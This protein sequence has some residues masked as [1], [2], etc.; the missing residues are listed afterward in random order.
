[1]LTIFSLDHRQSTVAEREPFALGPEARQRLGT[2]TRRAGL[3][4]AA[5]L[6]TCNRVALVTWL[7]DGGEDLQRLAATAER[8]LPATGGAFLRRAQ[9]LEGGEAI[10]H[11]HRVAAGLESQVC[12]D[13]QV[14]GQVRAA[15]QEALAA[16]TIGPELH[17]LFQSALGAGKQVRHETALGRRAASVGAL[18]ATW[19]LRQEPRRVLLIGAGRTIEAAGRVLV[20]GGRA[21][22]VVNRRGDK[23]EELAARLG[24]GAADW[25]SRHTLLAA[26][27][28]AIVA[29][30][31]AEPV[32]LSGPL[33]QAR[34]DADDGLRIVD[35]GVPR[36]VAGAVADIRGVEL[37][38]L[39]LFGDPGGSP[40]DRGAAHA[41]MAAAAH[42][43]AAWLAAR[44]TRG[45]EVA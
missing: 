40:A 9:R 23:G 39:E 6:V 34:G 26:A 44:G 38:G 43:C 33:R 17:R 5:C 36:N 19:L 3:G 13:C 21:V 28:A 32:I 41:I 11:L 14:L 4:Q 20:G 24:A 8:V 35:L 7:G 1:M 31:A 25:E 15:Y 16:R 37:T 42:R 12:G 30:S 10:T 18:A 2:I 45:R 27:D 29:T 22:T